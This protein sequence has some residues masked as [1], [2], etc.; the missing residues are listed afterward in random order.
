MRGTT[1]VLGGVM[2]GAVIGLSFSSDMT[3]NEMV[4]TVSGL[5]ACVLGSL[6]P[7]IDNSTSTVGKYFWLIN[8]TLK[9][10]GFCHSLL[11][12]AIMSFTTAVLLHPHLGIC[13]GAGML[14]HLLL[15]MLNP[16]GVQLLWPVR[17]MYK[18][19]IIQIYTDSFGDIIVGSLCLCL[20]IFLFSHHYDWHYFTAVF[21]KM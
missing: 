14:S 15:D 13:L 3:S 18:F 6:L 21:V 5:G 17:K 1:H 9:H 19:G 2:A 10:R 4:Y 11:F 8:W 12:V 20:A 16:K 7:D